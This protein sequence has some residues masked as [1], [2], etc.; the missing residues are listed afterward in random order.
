MPKHGR[1]AGGCQNIF[2]FPRSHDSIYFGNVFPNL[3]AEAF[4]QASGDDQFLRFACRLMPGHFED[5][6]D[7]LL[8]GALDER[9]GIHHNHVGIFGAAGEFGPGSG[10]QAHHDFAIDQVFGT[11]EADKADFLGAWSREGVFFSTSG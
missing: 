2:Q 9:A 5:G 10:Q 3:V 6:V 7:R 8:L 11:T 1:H 4:D